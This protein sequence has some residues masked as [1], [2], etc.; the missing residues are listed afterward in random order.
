MMSS[1]QPLLALHAPSL[2][3]LI[4]SLFGASLPIGFFLWLKWWLDN[5]KDE[6]PDQA[7]AEQAKADQAHQAHHGGHGH[8]G[9][10]HHHAH[11]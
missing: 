6:N 3:L 9:D 2:E 5:A 8:G 11:A 1:L 7:I 10:H 4:I